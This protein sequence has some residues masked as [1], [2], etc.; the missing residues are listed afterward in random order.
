MTTA[1]FQLVTV[2]ANTPDEKAGVLRFLQRK[3]ATSR[4]LLFASDDTAGL[5]ADVR[6]KV[7]IGRAVHGVAGSRGQGSLQ[8]R[9][10]GRHSGAATENFGG[11]AI[12]LHRLQQI[13]GGELIAKN[14]ADVALVNVASFDVRPRRWNFETAW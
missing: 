5:Q 7:A 11:H 13:L 9:W 4:N 10:F 8:H 1:D 12:G 3:H 6:S 2:S 14:P